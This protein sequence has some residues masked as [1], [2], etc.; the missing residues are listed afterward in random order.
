MTMENDNILIS[1]GWI[2]DL[3]HY[4]LPAPNDLNL[5]KSVPI[6]CKAAYISLGSL[7]PLLNDIIKRIELN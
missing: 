1:I 2:R 7:R 6:F 5:P 3:N 4:I